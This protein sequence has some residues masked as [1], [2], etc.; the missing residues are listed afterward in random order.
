MSPPPH[1]LSHRWCALGGEPAQQPGD[2]HQG[3]R[4]LPAPR[5]GHD[6][7]APGT[8]AREWQRVSVSEEREVGPATLHGLVG[9]VELDPA[10][11]P[12]GEQLLGQRHQALCGALLKSG[13]ESLA[14]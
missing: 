10:I 2:D 1:P 14:W 7:A 9:H 6:V 11:S 13:E 12:L 4:G 3:P 5:E 8:Y